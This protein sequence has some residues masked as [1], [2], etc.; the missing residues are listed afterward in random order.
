MYDPISNLGEPGY[1]VLQPIPVEIEKVA[2]GDFLASFREANISISGIDNDDA[3]EALLAEILDTFD[4]LTEE[5]SLGKSAAKQLR[6]L[7][8]YIA[9]R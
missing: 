1:Q 9:K 5:K 3:Y 4:S 8:T 2:P 7:K 6:V